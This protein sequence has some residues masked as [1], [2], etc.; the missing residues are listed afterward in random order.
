MKTIQII[1]FVLGFLS[2]AQQ[3]SGG[4]VFD[5]DDNTPLEFVGVYNKKDHTITNAD[6]KYLFSTTA[7]SI[8]FY[9]PGYESLIVGS[10]ILSDTI[11]LHKSVLELEEVIVTNAKT[12]FQKVKDSLASNY[13]LYPYKEKF[14]LRGVLRYNGEIIR[15]QDI[16]G[17]LQRKTLLYTSE[18]EPDKKDFEVEI[19]NMRKIGLERDEKEVYFIFDSFHGLFMNLIPRN[20]TGEDFDLAE[21]TFENGKKLKLSFQSSPTLKKEAVNGYYIINT[22]N[23]VMERFYMVETFKNGAYMKSRDTRYRTIFVEREISFKQ[24]TKNSKYYIESSKYN[25]RVE[26]TDASKSYTSFYDVSFLLTTTDNEGV[27][28]V[29]RNVSTSKDLFKIN[30]SY[31]P[32]FWH[33]QNE[34]LLTDEMLDFIENI[35]DSNNEFKIRSNIIE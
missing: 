33:S 26:L 12:T 1:I 7:D 23:Y 17:K 29:K 3:Q 31:H 2:T 11:Y 28:D 9:R 20:A 30:C 25:A 27:F 14:L 8:T 5:A 15:I 24:L 4:V 19:T 10:N 34:L 22:E 21:A 13:P 16:Q 35:H 6:G 32:E 18:I